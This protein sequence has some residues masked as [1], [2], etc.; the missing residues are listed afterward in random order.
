MALKS[1]SSTGGV[2]QTGANWPDLEI[3]LVVVA[4]FE[5]PFSPRERAASFW[6]SPEVTE[7]PAL[8][9]CVVALIDARAPKG[10]KRGPYK[11]KLILLEG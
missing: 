8:G 10:G 5:P 7:A 2:Y 6:H 4:T 3:L 11:K 9:G 1:G